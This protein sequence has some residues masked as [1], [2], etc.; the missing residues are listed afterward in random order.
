MAI[1]AIIIEEGGHITAKELLMV[2]LKFIEAYT[3]QRKNHIRRGIC[4]QCA[5]AALLNIL[6]L[7]TWGLQTYL[8]KK[9]LQ[10]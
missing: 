6:F 10:F 4:L 8:C 2:H 3:V 7:K 9:M 1:S 5:P